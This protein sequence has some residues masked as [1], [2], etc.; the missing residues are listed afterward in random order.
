[1]RLRARGGELVC[2]APVVHIDVRHGAARS[3]HTADGRSWVARRAVLA[4]VPAPTLY[5]ELLPAS[6]VPARIL[7]DLAA[8]EYDFATVK[9]DWA[10]AGPIPWRAPEAAGSATLHIGLDGDGLT[11]YAAALSSGR[12]P[13]EPL[14][15][16]GQMTTADP[17]RSP[18]GTESFWAYTHLPHR[19]AWSPKEIAGVVAGME[20]VL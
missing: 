12:I 17:T 20:R 5:R 1:T 18:A 15:I 14:L 7:D 19:R 4:D 9:V 11:R 3:V 8:F 2:R 16:C 6:V 10:L 13:D